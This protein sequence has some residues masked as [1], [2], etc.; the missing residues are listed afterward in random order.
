MS[1]SKKVS[2]PQ[3]QVEELYKT[4]KSNITKTIET[5]TELD[6]VLLEIFK[7]GKSVD[8]SELNNI[9][10]EFL[11]NMSYIESMKDAIEKISKD[12]STVIKNINKI[13]TKAIKGD[14]GSAKE[15]M[16]KLQTEYLKNQD[17]IAQIEQELQT[18]NKD[19]TGSIKKAY[20]FL[21]KYETKPGTKEAKQEKPSKGI[22][23]N[24]KEVKAPKKEPVKEKKLI[25]KKMEETSDSESD[26][27][28]NKKVNTLVI[29]DSSE[30]SDSETDSNVSYVESGSDDDSNNE[31]EES[32]DEN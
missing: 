4:L 20:M 5:S 16:A 26:S 18:L 1:K 22:T 32:D 19:R 15:E 27:Q 3:T 7:P 31:S 12:N 28:V 14:D 21:K 17:K 11:E 8:T 29:E 2:N 25:T 24:K 9:Y 13:L 30:G 23:K 6:K 10:K